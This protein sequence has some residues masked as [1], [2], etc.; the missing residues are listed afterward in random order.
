[1][2][3]KLISKFRHENN[4]RKMQLGPGWFLKCISF[5]H[6]ILTTYEMEV[7]E[8]VVESE[9]EEAIKQMED[10]KAEGTCWRDIRR[11]VKET[12]WNRLEW[13]DLFLQK[14]CTKKATG[15]MTSLKQ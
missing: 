7:E 13:T 3:A 9:I 2:R 4:D 8:D 1:M 15:P 12:E 11:N 5:W 14:R 10:R 6:S